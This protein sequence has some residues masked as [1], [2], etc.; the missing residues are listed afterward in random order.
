MIDNELTYSISEVSER[1]K[2]SHRTLHYYEQYFNIPIRRDDGGNR[3]Y[4]EENV[5]ILELIVDLK[6]KD[7]SLKGIKKMLQE[8]NMMPVFDDNLPIVV[9]D[10]IME[11]KEFFMFEIRKLI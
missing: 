11:F 9:D 3:R 8:R 6:Q 5:A 10:N 1:L 7:M 4:T 2:L